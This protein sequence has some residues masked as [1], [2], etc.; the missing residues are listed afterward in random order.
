MQP[1]HAGELQNTKECRRNVLMA[2][3]L[4]KCYGVTKPTPILARCDICSISCKCAS[5]VNVLPEVL[6]PDKLD[7]IPSEPATVVPLSAK[8]MVHN[9]LI[10]Y[11]STLF[12]TDN[13]TSAL[14]VGIEILTR[15]PDTVVQDM[16]ITV[17]KSTQ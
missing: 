7:D 14:M 1:T 8:V 4:D 5:C 15:L 6:Q 13:T 12:P 16:L 3:F 10:K 17:C 2:V 9:E 11:R